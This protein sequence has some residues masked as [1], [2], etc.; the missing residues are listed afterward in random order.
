[1]RIILGHNQHAMVPAGGRRAEGGAN[2]WDRIAVFPTAKK[3]PIHRRWGWGWGAVPTQHPCER[4]RV[5]LADR[6]GKPGKATASSYPRCPRGGTTPNYCVARFFQRDRTAPATGRFT[7]QT[8]R[9][10]S[11]R[12]GVIGRRGWAG[13]LGGQRGTGGASS[14]RANCRLLAQLRQD[15]ARQGGEEVTPRP[16]RPGTDSICYP[17]YRTPSRTMARAPPT[18][19]APM[20]G[21][22]PR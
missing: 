12:W 21:H 8:R 11:D 19:K 17:E 10:R 22:P 7:T 16:V 20:R 15:F 5:L 18:G 9:H 6:V 13:W 1:M 3:V 4:A 14:K 2:G